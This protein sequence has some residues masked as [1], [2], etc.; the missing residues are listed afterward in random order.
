[1]LPANVALIKPVSFLTCVVLITLFCLC[2]TV[3]S[4]GSI[5][6]EKVAVN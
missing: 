6:Q 5:K 1:M 3:F 2:D 4:V